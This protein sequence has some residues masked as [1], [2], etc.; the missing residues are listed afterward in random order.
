MEFD[1][2][3]KSCVMDY[4]TLL[5]ADYLSEE[6]DTARKDSRPLRSRRK[7]DRSRKGRKP[8]RPSGHIGQRTNK[9]LKNL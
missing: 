7:R 2:N 5:D 4:T 9:R 1:R 6:V 8:C 3:R